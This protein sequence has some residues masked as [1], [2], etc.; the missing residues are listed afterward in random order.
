MKKM[1]FALLLGD[2]PCRSLED[3]IENFN[4]EDIIKNFD[5]GVLLRWFKTY[6]LDEL[7]NKAISI[8]KDSVTKLNDLLDLFF[9]DTAK[10][11]ELLN[12]YKKEEREKI[13]HQE[14][15]R[16]RENEIR[17]QE[18]EFREREEIKKKE[19]IKIE[20][21]N[22]FIKALDSYNYNFIEELIINIS[23]DE[24]KNNKELSKRIQ[25]HSG[26]SNYKLITNKKSKVLYLDKQSYI[27]ESFDRSK[28]YRYRDINNIYPILKGIY[29][30]GYSDNSKIVYIE[31]D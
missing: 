3:V 23:T 13:I 15:A 30:K 2:K 25:I 19:E 1:K 18:E 5:N 21:I 8:D 22:R 20:I 31:I 28:I 24:I 17:I 9:D 27:T 4:A 14:E 6:D 7:Y 29:F 26:N 11:E 10:K 12:K 16:K